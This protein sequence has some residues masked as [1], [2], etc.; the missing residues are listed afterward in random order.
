MQILK[1]NQKEISLQCQFLW[2]QSEKHMYPVF[3]PLAV[4]TT[5]NLY[6]VMVVGLWLNLPQTFGVSPSIL[7]LVRLY[8]RLLYCTD[9]CGCSLPP[10]WSETTGR[11]TQCGLRRRETFGTVIH[12]YIH[13]RTQWCTHAHKQIH[14][15]LLQLRDGTTTPGHNSPPLST[16]KYTQYSPHLLWLH[17]NY[18]DLI[19][20]P[21]IQKLHRAK[22]NW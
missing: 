3:H 21:V 1:L 14:T 13:I 11:R 19:H 16:Y 8:W 9:S 18:T 20:S 6:D 2:L 5:T 15:N 7:L 10:C 22:Y 12:A 17:Y 4:M